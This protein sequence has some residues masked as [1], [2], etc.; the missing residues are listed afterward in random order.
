VSSTTSTPAALYITANSPGEVAG[1]LSPMVD[2]LRQALPQVRIAVLLLPCTFAT[3]QEEHV[4]RSLPGVTDVFTSDTILRLMQ[5]PPPYP[6]AALLHLGGDLAYAAR[7][8][9]RWQTPAWAYQWAQPRWDK[10]LLGYFVKTAADEQRLRRQ[11]IAPPKI[12]VVGD[13]IVDAVQVALTRSQGQDQSQGELL[14]P[15]TS[16]AAT[17]HVVLLTGS[18]LH[19]VRY[20]A[21][22]YLEVADR[23]RQQHP[24]ARFSLLVSP[25]LEF[26]SL[27]SALQLPPD[28]KFGGVSGRLDDSDPAVWTLQAPSG[29]VMRLIRA[30]PLKTMATADLVVSIPGTKTGEAGALARPTL[31]ILPCNRP[32]EVPYIGLIGLL[33]WIPLVGKHLKGWLLRTLV[34]G[35]LGLLAQPNIL[36]N[37]EI[38]PE[39]KGVLRPADVA[40][41]VLGLLAENLADGAAGDCAPLLTRMSQRLRELYSPSQGAA[42]RIAEHMAGSLALG[43]PPLAVGSDE[44]V[45]SAFTAPTKPAEKVTPS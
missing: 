41:R 14:A 39:L 37:E 23:V 38:V 32:E 8:A 26:S 17:P 1:F 9:R 44:V 34:Q 4:A 21:P 13:L 24:G 42:R 36:A 27:R 33:D 7:L 2:A 5:G 15:A 11:G 43:K 29:T 3:G 40:Q 45:R 6:A 12:H 28:S 31:M 35:K 19:E 20:L 16:S 22:F 30:H 10:H 18:R 25:F